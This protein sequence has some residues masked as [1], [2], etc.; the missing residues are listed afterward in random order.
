[1]YYISF[2]FQKNQVTDFALRDSKGKMI[3]KFG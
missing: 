2:E 3:F 1:M